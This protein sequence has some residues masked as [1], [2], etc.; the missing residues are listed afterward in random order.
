MSRRTLVDE[1]VSECRSMLD[2][3]N[4]EHIDD[5]LDILPALNRAQDRVVSML[6]RHYEEPLLEES[7]LTL[8]SGTAD[9]SIPDDA[10]EQRIEKVEINV[11]GY[12]QPVYR[13]SYREISKY[14]YENLRTPIPLYYCVIGNSFRL[15]PT[16]TGSYDGRLW[17]LKDPEP[18]VKSQGRIIT[19]NTAGNY[20]LLNELGDDLTTEIED[21]NCFIN[22]VDGQSGQIK[23]TGQ[24][25]SIDPSSN[26]ITLRST[27]SRSTVLGKT[28]EGSFLSAGIEPDDIICTVHGTCI[29][30]I[31][32]PFSLYLIQHAVAE[33]QYKLGGNADMAYR[34]LQDLEKVVKRTWVGREKT[35]RVKS[36]R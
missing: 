32:K 17:Y 28:V 8:T 29:P 11:S 22:V 9:Y 24:I 12:Y 35:F 36:N 13:I 21:L 15:L 34:V 20:L 19:V 23:Y 3:Q 5:T 18:L 7:P 6:A 33:L 10:L 4:Q 2:E 16:P 31:K 25:L 14:E 1:L 30:F 26:K 27:P